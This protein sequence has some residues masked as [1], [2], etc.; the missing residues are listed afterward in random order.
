MRIPERRLTGALTSFSYLSHPCIR[1]FQ[2]AHG[3]FMSID[4]LL[5]N[6]SDW[7]RF[8]QQL[9]AFARQFGHPYVP[10][11]DPQWSQLYQWSQRQ[12]RDKPYLSPA[13]V[14]QLDQLGFYWGGT[15]ADHDRRWDARLEELK[16]FHREHGH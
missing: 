4:P 14:A 5:P 13:Q 9:Q 6:L 2:Q 12:Q 8:Y 15:A 7:E 1:L 16:A 11:S 3:V 10:A